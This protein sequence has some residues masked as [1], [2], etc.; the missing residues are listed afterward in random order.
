LAEL[1]QLVLVLELVQLKQL[2][3]VQQLVLQLLLE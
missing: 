1:Q 3:L 2:E